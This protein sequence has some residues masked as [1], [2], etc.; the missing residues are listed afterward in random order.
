MPYYT[1][2]QIFSHNYFVPSHLVTSSKLSKVSIRLATYKLMSIATHSTLPYYTYTQVFP[3]NVLLLIHVVCATHIHGL[4]HNPMQVCLLLLLHLLFPTPIR[5]MSMMVGVT[6]SLY[7]TSCILMHI[8]TYIV[9]LS[10]LSVYS[11]HHLSRVCAA[12]CI[13][14]V[15]WHHWS[16]N[17]P[18]IQKEEEEGFYVVSGRKKL[19]CDLALLTCYLHAG[20]TH[21]QSSFLSG[22][23]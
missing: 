18:G 22:I 7:N 1:Y 23:D 17:G 2:T 16:T 14:S 5:P 4:V 10:I 11:C 21:L 19:L 8:S 20:F 6:T 12:P 13:C 15:G 9:T 3:H